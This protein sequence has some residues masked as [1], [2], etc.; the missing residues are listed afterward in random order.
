ML[1]Q[2]REF[3]A[4][5]LEQRPLGLTPRAVS[6][7]SVHIETPT[8]TA[9]VTLWPDYAD[10]GME[11]PDYTGGEICELSI[12]RAGDDE[13][14][15]FLHFL[16]EDLGR[17]E[18]LFG[19]MCEVLG[20][21]KAREAERVLLCCSAG[22]TTGLLAERMNEVARSLGL[23]Y[24][25]NALP[26]W[27][28]KAQGTGGYVAILLAPQVAHL[29]GELTAIHGTTPVFEIPA[30]VF[31]TYDAT[32]AVRL[33]MHVLRDPLEDYGVRSASYLPATGA[34]ATHTI[35]VITLFSVR[36]GAK[37]GYRLYRRGEV[38]CEGVVRKA[39]V[40]LLDVEDLLETLPARVVDLRAVDAVG[41]A[42]PGVTEAGVVSQ[43]A[44][45]MGSYELGP[46]LERRFGVPVF[47]DNN[48]NAATV[49]C[50]VASGGKSSVVFF[51]QELGHPGGG[52][53]AIVDGRLLL[54]LH[55]FAGESNHFVR[56]FAYDEVGGYDEARWTE[57]GMFE[58]ALNVSLA[59]ISLIAPEELFLAVDTVDDMGAFAEALAA[60][61][62]EDFVP[63][64]HVVDDYVESV[65]VGEMA[66]VERRLRVEGAGAADGD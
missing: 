23:G 54:G 24:E 22:M 19:E 37:L 43:F 28:A 32:A 46:H 41:I 15:F 42:V 12:T 7:R 16:L 8:A 11:W 14:L 59:C 65:Y 36:G 44:P 17:A 33:V 55:H 21:Q 6:E 52:A 62:G 26:L 34:E 58:I 57:R 63:A 39:R 9:E 2:A 50:H 10:G 1:R 27:Q 5:V 20:S 30:R 49:A 29:R 60:E 35:L 47:V 48:C 45:D 13:Q 3:L 31:G 25:F 4:W 51:R 38:V 18:E 64:L 53:G 56:R 40:D 66:L 61:V